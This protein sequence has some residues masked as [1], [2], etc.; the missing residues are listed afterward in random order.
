MSLRPAAEALAMLLA[1]QIY[2]GIGAIFC[3]HR[4]VPEAERAALPDNRALEIRP[5]DLR[6]MLAWVA[7]RGLEVIALDQVP[8]RLARPRGRK[9]ACFTFDDG[10]RDNLTLA[11]P[12]FREAGMPFAVHIAPGLIDGTASVWWYQIAAALE[13]REWLDFVWRDEKFGWVTDSPR[14]R[15]R[16]FGELAKVIRQ[17]PHAVREELV[18]VVCG[19]VGLDAAALQRRLMMTWAEVRA[20][21]AEPLVTLGAHT[22]T[23]PVLRLLGDDEALAEL[24]DSRRQLEAQLGGPV[25]HL[26]FP[27]GGANAVGAREFRLALDCGF[28]TAT[29]TRGANLF[30]AHARHLTALPR[31]TVSGNYPV[32]DRARKLESGLLA[33]REWRGR[34]VV[35]E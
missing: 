24:A 6:A 14:A 25:W 8:E 2:G 5:E 33:A 30:P 32:P 23:H 20:L 13:Q 31:L 11:L 22:V 21:A 28:T 35:T 18:A 3:L 27:F 29:T 15:E 4:I 9:F 7:A 17:Q 10:Y 26:A 1:R 34:R 19:A 12:V 16:A